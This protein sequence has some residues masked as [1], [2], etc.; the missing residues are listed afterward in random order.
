[1]TAATSAVRSSRGSRAE[2]ARPVVA[3]SRRA[4]GTP[5]AILSTLAALLLATAA[6][7][8]AEVLAVRGDTVHTLA[9]EPITD[10]V[11][12]IRDGRIEAVGPASEVPV[13]DGARQLEAAVVTPGL[14][15]AHSVV[16]LAGHLN[17]DHDQDQLEESAPMQPELR[18]IDAYNARER[19]IE[20]VRGFGVTTLHTGH[21]PGALISG[22]TMIVKTRGDTVDEALVVPLAMVAA[23]LGERAMN[24]G[25]E[26]PGTRGKAVAMLR[27][28]LIEARQ[29]A[30]DRQAADEEK[31]PPRDL[32]L[33]VLARVLD[34]EVPLLVTADRHQD[35]GS[36]L[37]VAEEFGFRLV[38]DS[39]ADA[40]QL[41][42][43]IRAAGVPVIV[44]PTMARPSGERENVSFETAAILADAGIPIALQS[45][46]ES[47]V[48][49]TRVVLFE[50]AIAAANGLGSDRA[51]AA[52]TRGAAELLGIA[53]R[54][55]TL[56]AGKDGDLALYDGDPFEYTT[57]CLG[58]VI[59]GEVFPGERE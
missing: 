17:S 7:V 49:K 42:D 10:G 57:H 58:V 39:A 53:D 45:G 23:T 4:S 41:V 35:I 47:Y 3:A 21:G 19:L 32:G 55:G 25:G 6:A 9:G 2:G 8:H 28:R 31:R 27:E 14:I 56:E 34:G 26:S 46:F 5:R 33:E 48:P 29:Y 44:H 37:R 15:D 12:V 18:A 1:M 36:A 59:E 54:V 13:P 38:L 20:W 51:L 43:P 11:V 30:A 22:Q 16:G 40:H 52:I 24:E 50:A